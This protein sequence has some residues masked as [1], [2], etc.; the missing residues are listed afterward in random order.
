MGVQALSLSEWVKVALPG[1]QYVYTTARH[2]TDEYATRKIGNLAWDFALRGAIYLV[3]KRVPYS[4]PSMFDYIAIKASY[5]PIK[6]LVAVDY[7]DTIKEQM[8]A[9]P[10][11]SEVV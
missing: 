11:V 7:G 6:S 8:R 3:Q 5:P 2:L 1:E 9:K 4:T 10:T